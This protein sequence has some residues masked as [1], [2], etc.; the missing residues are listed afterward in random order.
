MDLDFQLPGLTWPVPGPNSDRQ[1]TTKHEPSITPSRRHL[2][3]QTTEVGRTDGRRVG[4]GLRVSVVHSVA[5]ACAPREAQTRSEGTALGRRGR[6]GFD[7]PI[8]DNA[9]AAGDRSR[10]PP[11]D[12]RLPTP[13]TAHRRSQPVSPPE[14]T[15]PQPGVVDPLGSTADRMPHIPPAPEMGGGEQVAG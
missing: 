12:P 15:D 2:E 4:G 3:G 1:A 5:G 6:R 14:Q 11:G 9:A 8:M 10:A 7:A 13:A